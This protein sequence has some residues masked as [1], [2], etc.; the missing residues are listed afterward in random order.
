MIHLPELHIIM[1]ALPASIWIKVFWQLRQD[2]GHVAL[3]P[4]LQ[5]CKNWYE[6]SLPCMYRHLQLDCENLTRFVNRHTGEVP[7][8]GLDQVECLS[9]ELKPQQRASHEDREVVELRGNNATH[10]LWANLRL[11][12]LVLQHTS[13]LSTFSISSDVFG[14]AAPGYWIPHEYLIELLRSLP[15]CCVHLELDC[16]GS[17]QCHLRRG[18]ICDSIRQLLPRL[19]SLRLRLETLCPRV[20]SAAYV[21]EQQMDEDYLETLLSKTEV[22]QELRSIVLNTSLHWFRSTILCAGIHKCPPGR[23][24]RRLQS[25]IPLARMMRRLYLAQKLPNIRRCILIDAQDGDS[26]YDDGRKYT[27]NEAVHWGFNR[28]D[29]L[30]DSTWSLPFKMICGEQLEDVYVLLRMPGDAEV[31]SRLCWT[32]EEL[33][34]LQTWVYS[35]TGVRYPSEQDNAYLDQ[36]VMAT[37]DRA[38]FQARNACTTSLWENED[39]TTTTLIRATM[40]QGLVA[41]LPLKEITP[42]G[43]RRERTFQDELWPVEEFHESPAQMVTGTTYLSHNFQ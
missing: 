6:I 36:R 5:V 2:N 3:L 23:V 39:K 35:T 26:Q 41:L 18:H 25:R 24:P 10:Q 43:W 33:V 34:E 9:L 21:F 16:N 29:I 38:T 42:P 27:S 7:T 17:D 37:M 12:R 32:V 31:V 11:L 22:A 13:H 28:R 8:A 15:Q 14:N 40:L 4:V 20:F 1:N 19:R 30:S